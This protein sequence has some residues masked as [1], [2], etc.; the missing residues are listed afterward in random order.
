MEQKLRDA[1]G[2][3]MG[4]RMPLLINTWRLYLLEVNSAPSLSTPTTLD[5]EIKS[6]MLGEAR[7]SPQALHISTFHTYPGQAFRL[8]RLDGSAKASISFR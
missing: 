2:W 6:S 4:M 1:C 5:E 7:R 8:L 3:Y